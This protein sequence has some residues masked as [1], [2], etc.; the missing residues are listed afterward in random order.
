M[1]NGCMPCQQKQLNQQPSSY[2][3]QSGVLIKTKIR[4]NPLQINIKM[5]T[6]CSED[7]MLQHK[8]TETWAYLSIRCRLWRQN[9]EKSTFTG[10]NTIIFEISTSDYPKTTYTTKTSVGKAKILCKQMVPFLQQKFLYEIIPLRNVWG[11]NYVKFNLRCICN[12]ST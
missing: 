12:G 6:H 9:H 8:I 5:L 2:N 1:H 3:C 10:K 4:N 11:N 7:V